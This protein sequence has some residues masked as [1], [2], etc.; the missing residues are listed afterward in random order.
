MAGVVYKPDADTRIELTAPRPRFAKRVSWLD[1][2]EDANDWAYV[3][4]EF[5]GGTYAVK[6]P[7]GAEDQVNFRDFRLLIGFESK[8]S[9]GIKTLFEAGY[10]FGRNIEFEDD[11]TEFKPSDT[12]IFRAGLSF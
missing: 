11:S 2:S 8:T 10:V 4:G 9:S 6:R 7:G 3:S 5:G 1:D 12:A